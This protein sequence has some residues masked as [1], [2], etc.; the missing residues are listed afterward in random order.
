MESVIK[1]SNKF[2]LFSLATV[3]FSLATASFSYAAGNLVITPT[4]VEFKEGAKSQEIKLVNRSNQTTTY[5]IYF[6]H[7]SMNE[8]GA[9]EEI[10]GDS[11]GGEKFADDLIV[12]SPKKAT[13]KA[14]EVQ[15][16]RLMLKKP[17]NL[18]EGEYRSH[19]AF[20]EEASSDETSIEAKKPSG[21]AIATRVTALFNVSIPVIVQNG[22]TEAT[23]VIKEAKVNKDGKSVLVKLARSGNASVNGDLVATLTSAD[24]N[25]HDLGK[26]AGLSVF[27]PYEAREV[28]LPLA[29]PKGVKLS[30]GTLEVNYYGKKESGL[31]DKSKVLANKKV[32]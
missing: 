25:K 2:G 7:L 26:I 11:K 20:Q 16:I 14:G 4:R 28:S 18:Q 22:K 15:T 3:L 32:N 19:L 24:N 8:K 10:K 27:Y 5:R 12:F 9:Y 21:K 6:K 1:K 23:I 17:A 13:L 29:L 31:V 30:D